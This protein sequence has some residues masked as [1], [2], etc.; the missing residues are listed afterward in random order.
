PQP[1]ASGWSGL[2]RAAVGTTLVVGAPWRSSPAAVHVFEG[3]PNSPF[4]GR[5]LLSVG[6]PE[7]VPGSQ[8]GESL[9]VL[10]SSLVTGAPAVE[11]DGL[12]DAGAAHLFTRVVFECGNGVPEG[13]EECDDGNAV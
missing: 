4:F 11:S 7:G 10:G 8:F 9:A 2:A 1:P 12:P 3:D 6:G 13:F 5:L